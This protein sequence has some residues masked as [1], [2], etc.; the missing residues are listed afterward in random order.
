MGK[1][2][3]KAGKALA[4]VDGAWREGN[5]RILGPQDH[6]VWLSS[7]VFDGARAFGGVAPDLD[8]H[9]AR[10]VT[11]AKMIG[12]E[13]PMTGAEITRLAWDGIGRFP[14]GSELYICPMFYAEHGFVVPDPASTRFVMTVYEAP[15]PE[16][17]GFTACLS[18]FRRPAKDMAP[19]EAKASCLYPNV[20]RIGRE[21]AQKGCDTAVVRDPNGNVAEF[22]YTNLFFAKDGVVHTP[23]PNGTFLNG[24]TRQRVVALLREAGVEVVERAIDFAELLD[25]DEV[26]SSGNY[27]K[28]QP[29]VRLED[30]A[31]RPGPVYARARELYFAFAK[32]GAGGSKAG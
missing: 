8:L 9:C 27:A 18:S 13:P 25:A 29:C 23:A 14:S 21:A 22:A 5:P 19:T 7:V 11:S 20:A 4:F 2:N 1:A 6:A 12:L 3:E 31:F 16:P 15:L 10:T 24:I 32:S 30:R 17:T 28:V 26:F